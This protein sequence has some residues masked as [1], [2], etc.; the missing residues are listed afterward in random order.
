M[1]A[2]FNLVMAEEYKFVYAAKY[3]E[4]FL[5]IL[6][7]QGTDARN[8]YQQFLIRKTVYIQSLFDADPDREDEPCSSGEN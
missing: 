7:Y 2:E 8:T 1:M 4:H 6:D 3:K 5:E